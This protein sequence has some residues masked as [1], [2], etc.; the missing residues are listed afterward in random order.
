[1]NYL[2][3]SVEGFRDQ[4][5]DMKDEASDI[6]FVQKKTTKGSRKSTRPKDDDFDNEEIIWNSKG[7]WGRL[8]NV[9]EQGE[10]GW[11]QV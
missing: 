3:D 4:F 8:L 9:I 1:M 2:D 5:G 11:E 10:T 7:N 6:K